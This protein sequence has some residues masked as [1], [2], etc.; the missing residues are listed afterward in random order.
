MV[1]GAVDFTSDDPDSPTTRLLLRGAA[2]GVRLEVTDAISF[3]NPQQSDPA[4]LE[5]RNIGSTPAVI[6][7]VWFER[8]EQNKYFQLATP[9]QLPFTIQ[10]GQKVDLTIEVKQLPSS[11][12]VLEILHVESNDLQRPDIRVMVAIRQ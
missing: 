12:T 4:T 1:D 10:P 6:S 5:I 7:D 9:V 3:V 8:F 11:G 2:S